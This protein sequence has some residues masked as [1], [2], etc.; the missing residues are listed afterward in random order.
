MLPAKVTRRT[1]EGKTETEILRCLK[2]HIAGEC[3][4]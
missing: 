3:V 2:G 4:L 1:A